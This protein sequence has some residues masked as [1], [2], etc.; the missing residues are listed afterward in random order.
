MGNCFAKR[1]N[2]K[3]SITIN[4]LWYYLTNNNT[5]RQVYLLN[6]R[7]I[8]RYEIKRVYNQLVMVDLFK[9]IQYNLDIVHLT[10][11]DCTLSG[12]YFDDNVTHRR[13][14]SFKLLD[15]FARNKN[16]FGWRTKVTVMERNQVI[17][18]LGLC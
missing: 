10:M 14:F 3:S 5:H 13:K 6:T 17:E 7:S 1:E 9:G 2:Y 12:K 15:D 16:T 8:E 4:S 18:Y 11:T